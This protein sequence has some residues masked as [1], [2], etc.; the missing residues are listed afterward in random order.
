M[1][2]EAWIKHY[3]ALEDKKAAEANPASY[4]RKLVTA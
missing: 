1:P 2:A 3:A 4:A